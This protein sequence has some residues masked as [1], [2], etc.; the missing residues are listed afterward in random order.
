M[1]IFSRIF[2]NRRKVS[3]SSAALTAEC[4]K[5]LEFNR[6][7]NQLLSNDKFLARSDY[8]HIVE[9]LNKLHEEFNEIQ[10]ENKQYNVI[11]AEI[12]KM[13]IMERILGK[14]P[15]DIKELKP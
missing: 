6:A 14:Y 7:Y 8:K 9:N 15:D 1:S 12:K 10:N 11:F 4:E 5:L 3:K 13:S 2:S